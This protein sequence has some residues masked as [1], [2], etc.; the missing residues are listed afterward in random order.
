VER[1]RKE[2][3][4]RRFRSTGDRTEEIVERLGFDV[5]DR[6]FVKGFEELL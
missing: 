1:V 2:Y 4:W 3:V 6:E 5:E